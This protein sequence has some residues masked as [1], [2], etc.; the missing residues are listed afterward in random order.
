MVQESLMIAA[1]TRK[2]T[3]NFTLE[4]LQDLSTLHSIDVETG[5]WYREDDYKPMKIEIEEYE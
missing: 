5:L 2:L 1:T 3:T 4:L